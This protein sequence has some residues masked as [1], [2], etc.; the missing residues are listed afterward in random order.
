MAPPKVEVSSVEKSQP[1]H[2]VVEIKTEAVRETVIKDR[3]PRRQWRPTI[4][5]P[6]RMD[7]GPSTTRG[8]IRMS[9][10]LRPPSSSP[11][12]PSPKPK[13]YLV[14]ISMKNFWCLRLS[15]QKLYVSNI[16]RSCVF[17]PYGGVTPEIV[18]SRYLAEPI[19]LG[20][21]DQY[22]FDGVCRS[23]RTYE[24]KGAF[25]DE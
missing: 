8:P 5:P 22:Q 25:E 24:S 11:K 18:E 16:E 15:I 17:L 2:E 4:T 19:S 7:R 20:S 6:P 10:T 21:R 3:K 14:R 9:S 23:F 13:E 12:L 1:K